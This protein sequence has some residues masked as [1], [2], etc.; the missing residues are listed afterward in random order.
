[1]QSLNQYVQWF[2]LSGWAKLKLEQ[3]RRVEAGQEEE[4]LSR[5]GWQVIDHI[6]LMRDSYHQEL[7]PLI[8]FRFFFVCVCVFRLIEAIMPDG[9][10][11][12]KDLQGF[13]T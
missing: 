7:A 12:F 10:L 9:S 4:D 3:I 8:D 6:F 1:M 2:E 11:D 13:G 5:V